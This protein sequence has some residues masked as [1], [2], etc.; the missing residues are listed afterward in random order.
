[1]NLRLN[2]FALLFVLIMMTP[3]ALPRIAV[4]DLEDVG[5]GAMLGPALSELVRAELQGK[6]FLL[7][8]RG[9]LNQI[10]AEQCFASSELSR[11]DH[12]HLGRL[13]Q[14]DAVV[15]GSVT[16]L[17]GI[18][19]VNLRALSVV[20]GKVLGAVSAEA[21]NLDDLPEATESACNALATRI[22]AL[23]GGDPRCGA[24]GAVLFR[25]DFDGSPA[26]YWILDGVSFGDSCMSLSPDCEA[27]AVE[28]LAFVGDSSWCDY[29][30]NLRYQTGS[31]DDP[32]LIGWSAG[33]GN[34]APQ[35]LVCEFRSADRT[36]QQIA[37]VTG[38][39]LGFISAFSL[40]RAT[41][42]T[43]GFDD[44]LEFGKMVGGLVTR[45][46]AD[47]EWCLTTTAGRGNFLVL[48]RAYNP[49]L[50]ETG[51]GQCKKRATV[52][53]YPVPERWHD[54]KVVV[55]GPSATI[56]LDGKMALARSDLQYSSGGIVL[57]SA[58][59]SQ[60]LI[61]KVSVTIP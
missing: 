14:A 45:I 6:G 41:E 37:E 43:A 52:P 21:R 49:T 23:P 28:S 12:G 33:D 2:S 48:S 9:K 34:D 19:T 35:G 61:D 51:D 47:P 59:D 22:E 44:Y 4:L 39:M 10:I 25:D 29:T 5:N 24:I 32:L 13:A 18:Y 58:G 31:S 55:R 38:D 40:A 53:I 8:E 50:Y 54:L 60:A 20:D 3:A 26:N 36:R 1:M 17:G 30:L 15:T 27:G 46:I 7:A 57:A 16:R 11:G 56:F 42:Y